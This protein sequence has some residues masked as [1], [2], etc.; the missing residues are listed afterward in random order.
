M[1]QI[2]F[3]HFFIEL[4][5]IINQLTIRI[6]DRAGASWTVF[7]TLAD[8]GINIL[9]YSI[10]DK[11][12]FGTLRLI[13]DNVKNAVKALQEQNIEV[14]QTPVYS[15]NVPNEPGS[16]SRVLKEL[17][18]NQISLDFLYAFQYRGISQAIL[19]SSDMDKLNVCLTNY[20]KK[21]ILG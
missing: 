20:E 15:M 14:E 7:Q 21:R 9:S 4:I 18:D 12:D 1:R 5:M 3:N 6:A 13:V 11:P 10:D 17:A 8:K 19:H 16:M 2:T